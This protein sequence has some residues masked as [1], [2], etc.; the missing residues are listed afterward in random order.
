LQRQVRIENALSR[1]QRNDRD[2][3]LNRLD[4]LFETQSPERDADDAAVEAESP[5]AADTQPE[6]IS[7]QRAVGQARAVLEKA[8][9]LLPNVEP[10]EREE[11]DAVIERLRQ[12]ITA[13]QLADIEALSAELAEALFYLEDI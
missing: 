9:R 6:T 5:R 12:A 10:E 4:L 2:E 8:E 7:V 3:A 1:F 13:S 11:L